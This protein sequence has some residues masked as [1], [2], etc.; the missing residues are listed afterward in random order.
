MLR[1]WMTSKTWKKVVKV[2]K[3]KLI[4]KQP[5]MFR[6]KLL[7]KKNDFNKT[8]CSLASYYFGSA[9]PAT[10]T[11]WKRWRWPRLLQKAHVL[12]WPAEAVC[13]W[14]EAGPSAGGSRSWP[15]AGHCRKGQVCHIG[16]TGA[17]PFWHCR[18]PQH[19][20]PRSSQ[21]RWSSRKAGRGTTTILLYSGKTGTRNRYSQLSSRFPTANSKSKKVTPERF[22]WTHFSGCWEYDNPGQKNRW[23]NQVVKGIKAFSATDFHG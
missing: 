16:H 7:L 10:Y 17:S 8:S 21:R 15:E 12:C 20:T 23:R 11:W 9:K 2:G 6:L 14:S 19:R 3:K 22:L 18:W 13:S 1:T 5:T 4:H